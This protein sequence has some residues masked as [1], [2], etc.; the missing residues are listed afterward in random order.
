MIERNKKAQAVTELTIFGA[1]LIFVI[2]SIL[3][4][5]VEQ[6]MNQ[7]QSL[8]AM[9]YAMSQ[10]LMGVRNVNKSRDSA[11]VI[12]IEDRLSPDASKTGSLERLPLI[13]SGSGNFSNTLFMPTDWLE[14]HNIPVT[15]LFVNGVH[16]TL[17]GA[18]FVIYDIRIDPGNVNQVRVWDLTHN[19]VKYIPRDGNWNDG[20]ATGGC[21]VFYALLPSNHSEFCPVACADTT[22]DMNQR[23][24]LN[25]NDDYTDDI[26]AAD[27]PLMSWQWKVKRGLVDQLEINEDE[28]RFPQ[29]DIDGDRKE[30]T[31]YAA[32]P[33]SLWN[34]TG[35]SYTVQLGNEPLVSPAV[36]MAALEAAS[37]VTWVD[38]IDPETGAVIGQE[39]AP[40]NVVQQL[41]VL[42]YQKGD[43]DGSFD[44]TDLIAAGMSPFDRGLRRSSSVYTQTKDGTY[45]EINEGRAYVPNYAPGEEYVR[46]INKKDT[47]D[48]ISRVYKFDNNSGRYCGTRSGIRWPTIGNEPG[49]LPNPVQYCVGGTLGGN[50]FTNVTAGATCYDIGTNLLFIRSRI[51]DKSG[52]K[53][54]TQTQ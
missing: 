5:S 41:Y 6:G 38:V 33:N 11:S 7:N 17:S 39:I 31:L 50:C 46:S 4:N 52:R 14:H 18:K 45:L 44:D 30:E 53:W 34:R 54:V 8:K 47:I 1:I 32:N 24:D 3:R 13:Q 42:D 26:A 28:G 10:S 35:A 27:R 49:G 16:F 43:V 25:R 12:F 20:C 37:A 48:V 22:I 2:G 9:R 36:D 21:P 29:W 19:I 51:E 15:D 40:R 23:F